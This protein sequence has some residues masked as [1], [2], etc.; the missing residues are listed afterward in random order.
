MTLEEAKAFYF[1]YNG[2]SFHMDREEPVKS[3]SFRRLNIGKDTLREWD[4]ELLDGLFARL[5]ADPA[6]VWIVHGDILKIVGRNNGD[7]VRYLRRLLDEMEKSD[8]LDLF[9]VTLILENMAGR[10]ESMS[11]GG[12]RLFCKYPALIPRMNDVA[13][14]LIAAGS[15]N[16]GADERFESAAR[17]YRSAYYKWHKAQS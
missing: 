12:V 7:A 6:H 15:A 17:R 2:Y 11:D 16:Q 4:E 3:S 13:E 5:W 9:N 14:R 1:Q 8:R 10:T